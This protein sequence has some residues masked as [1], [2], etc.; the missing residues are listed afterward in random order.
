M[1]PRLSVVIVTFHSRAVL[2]ACLESLDAAVSM[3][4][5]RIV[6]DNHS[7][8]GTVE[9]LRAHRPDVRVIENPD[10]R[11]FA[12]AVNQGLEQATGE[13]VLLLNPD[14]RVSREGIERLLETLRDDP[15]VAAAAPMLRDERGTPARS[16]GR[17]P[18]LWTL[19]CEHLG[20][21]AA[22]PHQRGFGG[23]KYGEVP[24]ERLRDVGWASGAALL[25][26]RHAI[27][28]LGGL[29][30][31]FFMYMEEVDW[32]R[33]ARRAGLRVRFVPEVGF[34][35]TGQHAAPHAGGRTYL[36]NLHSRVRYFRKH[37]GR[38]AAWTAKGILAASLA[39]KWVCARLGT[40]R[41][42]DP[43][44]YARGLEALWAA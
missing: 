7:G 9:W 25:M 3:P 28:R 23:Y 34:V 10:N 14:C 8:D 40:A 21:A 26:A 15:T 27:E 16:C 4:H 44:V 39:L 29:D 38:L 20:L 42:G 32:C 5:E 24:L 2:A 17:F 18:T 33:R 19:F 35:H 13:T 1:T 36:Y 43:G 12:R 41:A 11:G 31:G 6:I 30:G 22:F 37:H